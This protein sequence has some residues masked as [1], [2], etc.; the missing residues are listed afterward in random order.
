MPNHANDRQRTRATMVIYGGTAAG[1]MATV[2]AARLGHDVA[3][4]EPTRHVGGITVEGLGGSDIDNHPF[5]NSVAVGGL[6][7]AFYERVG[8]AYGQAEPVWRFESSVAER[9]FEQMLEEAGVA[10]YRGC[11]LREGDGVELEGRR[12]VA[13]ETEEAGRFE[14]EAF[15]DATIEGDLLAAAGVTTT[16]GREANAQ[17]DETK[18]GIRGEN[19]YRQFA[20]RVDPYNTP[21]KPDTGLIPTVQDE[22]LGT[23]GEGD[24]RV[25]AYCFRLCFTDEPANQIPFRK[26]DDYDPDRYEIYRRYLTAG[27]KLWTPQVK[28]PNR[29]TDLGSWHD[30]SGNLYGMNHE[31]PGGDHATRRRVLDE[32]LSFIKGLCWFLTHDSAVPEDL[33]R[34]WARWGVCRDEFTD[35]DGWPR[36]FYVR[37]ARRMVSDYVITEHHTKREGATPVDDP[38]ALAYWP[39]DTHHVRRIVRAGAAYNEGFVFGGEDWGPFGISYRALTPRAA[40]CVNL[41]TPTCVSSSHVAYGAVRIEWTFMSL[42]QAAATAADLAVRGGCDVQAVPYGPLRERLLADGQVLALEG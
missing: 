8:Q 19:T 31:Y 33:R 32:H 28:L 12:I 6:A 25:Q 38:V 3:L 21:G 17:Y 22:P 20:V 4:V 26:P 15:I 36:M 14:G 18:N 11:R 9:V 16:I 13:M 7:L 29:K 2:Q 42:G 39:P 41:L 34:E 27:G 35:N 24:H 10:V 1:V 40:E 23:P 30:L 5:K 37:D